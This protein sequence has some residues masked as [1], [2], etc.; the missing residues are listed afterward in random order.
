[1]L[2]SVHLLFLFCLAVSGRTMVYPKAATF[3]FAKSAMVEYLSQ[4]APIY[5]FSCVKSMFSAR[6]F[7]KLAL[8]RDSGGVGQKILPFSRSSE[9]MDIDRPDG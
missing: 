5:F 6:F 3:R 7:E 2:R 1:M 9:V 4:I 8:Q